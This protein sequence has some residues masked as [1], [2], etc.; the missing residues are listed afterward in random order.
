MEVNKKWL[1]LDLLMGHTWHVIERKIK[2]NSNIFSLSNWQN[3]RTVIVETD[4]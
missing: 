2:D 3:E 4:S 1:N